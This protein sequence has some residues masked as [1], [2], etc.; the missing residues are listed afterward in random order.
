MGLVNGEP[1]ELFVDRLIREAMESG[2]FDDL[3]G[4]GKPIPGAGGIDDA[5]WWVREWIRRSREDDSGRSESE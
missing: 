5:N 4:T 3:P 1:Q 2:D